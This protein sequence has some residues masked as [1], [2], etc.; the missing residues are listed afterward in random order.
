MKKLFDFSGG[1]VFCTLFSFGILLPFFAVRYADGAG[2]AFGI[3]FLLTAAALIWLLIRFVFRAA[4]L[5]EDGVRYRGIFIARDALRI[6]AQYDGRFHESVYLLRD[7]GR[8]YSFLSEKELAAVQ[9]RVEATKWNRKRLEAYTGLSL[10]PAAKPVR[11]RKRR[12]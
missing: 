1:M 4:A 3:L 5:R 7:S 12:F 2:A 10:P 8:S 9:I 11:R 6:K